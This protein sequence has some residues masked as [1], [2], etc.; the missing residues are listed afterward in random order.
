MV[1]GLAAG[2]CFGQA[3]W[4]TPVNLDNTQQRFS[5]FTTMDFDSSGYVHAAFQHF[6]GSS[7]E[8]NYTTN[9]TGSW[10][11]E[12]VPLPGLSGGR[13]NLCLIITPD[14]IIHLFLQG[15]T[16]GTHAFELTK[17][18]G[19][20]AWSAPQQISHAAGGNFDWAAQDDT[21]GILA[22]WVTI[23]FGSGGGANYVRYKPFG[24]SW[25]P[26]HQIEQGWGNK[27]PGDN[28]VTSSPSS[29]K[30]YVAYNVDKPYYRVYENGSIGPRQTIASGG[31]APN[32]HE[33]PVNGE[34]VAVWH[35]NWRNWLKFSTDG[36]QTWSADMDMSTSGS[37]LD[38]NPYVVFDNNG[39][40][41]A[42]WHK[43]F[44]SGSDVYFRSRIGGVWQSEYSL[45]PWDVGNAYPWRGSLNVRG[46]DLHMLFP[47]DYSPNDYYD[48]VYMMKPG[49]TTPAPPVLNELTLSHELLIADG[50]TPHSLT[51][52]G[53][54]LNG[55][56]DVKAMRWLINYQGDNAGAYRGYVSWGQTVA[57]IESFGG[58]GV[59]NISP[60]N[61]GSG[62][63]GIRN[64]SFGM[65][66][67]LNIT[68]VEELTAGSARIV[69][70][71]F[72][73]KPQYFTD[74]PLTNNDIS[75]L[76]QDATTNTG[77]INQDLDFGV[78][79]QNYAPT[80]D[81]LVLSDDLLLHDDNTLY[82]LQMQASDGNGTD[83]LRVMRWLINYQGANGGAYRGY[84]SWGETEEYIGLWGGVESWTIWPVTAGS[85][86]WGIRMSP[87]TWG[88]DNYITPVSSTESTS[89]NTRTFTVAFTVKPQWFID[90][91][92]TD[93]DISVIARDTYVST[94]WSNVDLSFD[95][96][97]L[98]MDVPDF[99]RDSDVDAVDYGRFQTCLSGDGIDYIDNA[100]SLVDFNGDDDVDSS[101]YDDFIGCWSGPNVQA[102]SNCV[103]TY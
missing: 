87:S 65:D 86:Y 48:A 13:N 49:T 28:F 101:D 2:L 92:L 14:D 20:G 10:V 70:F 44:S 1:F 47:A 64:N 11:K 83:D 100:C 67:Y 46:G 8:V 77:W 98:E 26:V 27:W 4:T 63:W 103:P 6:A 72:N 73:V 25:G 57:D 59:W 41:H 53:S 78:A 51:M 31:F 62:Y 5:G 91:P 32:V 56:A 68:S 81:S 3:G 19:G 61:S 69:T 95:I 60:V 58:A 29:D 38:K 80:V 42:T 39:D 9:R 94:N 54:D 33:N 55:S 24:G 99:D 88:Q 85:G 82:T 40:L 17:P 76:V 12:V 79:D 34:L 30:F 35:N 96:Y 22:V 102:N 74:G 37:Q 52:R 97:P 75:G 71:N 93:N 7:V 15:D 23:T 21:G 84:L 89:G 50:A 16:S 66:D 43:N 45:S 90:G 18:V 36:G